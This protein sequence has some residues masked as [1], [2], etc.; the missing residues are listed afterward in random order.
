MSSR[1]SRTSPAGERSSSRADV[2]RGAARDDH[3][4]VR[5]RVPLAVLLLSAGLGALGGGVATNPRNADARPGDAAVAPPW[6]DDV[7]ALTAGVAEV[8][9]PGAV[10][11]A[12]AVFGDLAFPVLLGGA[13]GTLR[14]PLAGAATFGKGRVVAIAHG[15]FLSAGAAK[16]ADTARFLENAVRWAAGRA[17]KAPRVGVIASDLAPTLV[18]RGFAAAALDAQTWPSRLDD[19]DVVVVGE[20]SPSD[21]QR[22]ALDAF[23]R[24]GGG[25]VT[26]LCPWGWKQ[27]ARAPSLRE[28]GLQRLLAPAGLAF[29]E[30]TVERTGAQGF[31]VA[32][33]PGLAFHAARA[34]ELLAATAGR[35][36]TGLDV[37]LA[38]RVAQEAVGAL[39]PDEARLW[40]RVRAL[41]RERA[42]HLVPTAREP[43]RADRPLDRFLLAV[44][45][46]L[47]AGLPAGD[48]EAHAAAADF[49]GQTP[50]GTKAVARTVTV[51][52]RVAGWCSTGLFAVAG[53][54]VRVRAA[55]TTSA[56]PSRGPSRAPSSGARPDEAPALAV[57]IGAHADVLGSLDAWP[58]VPEVTLERPLPPEGLEV[59]S[60]FGGLVYVVVPAGGRGTIAV[61]VEGAVEAPRYE[62]GTTTKAA[63][64]Q[65]R[66]APGPWAEL[67]T[68]KVVLTVPSARVRD[69]DDPAPLL[70]F[71]DRVLDADADL[72][73]IPHARARPERIVADVEISAGYMHSGYPIMTHLDA[74]ARMVDAK[75]LATEG[76]W[77]LF[78]ELGHNHQADDWTFDGTV[79]VTCNLFTLYV[80][81]HVCG[82]RGVDGH[83]ALGA[84]AAKAAAHV[85]AGAPFD[86]WKADPFLA[87]ATYVHL[88]EG[89]GWA[90]FRA[91]FAAYRTLPDAARP[92]SDAAK[93]DAWMVRFS[94][95]V[96]RDLGPFFD[97]W[98]IP[99]GEA[100]RASLRGLPPWMPPGFPPARAR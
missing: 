75:R 59:A 49:P 94:Q 77:G 87:L 40:P 15:G 56:D 36:A 89:F 26:G 41:L 46:D 84:R 5:R 48:V 58:R 47:L 92:K 18:A 27:V 50:A 97:A 17:S 3:G 72:A 83:D 96:G 91:V 71:W 54:P 57:R 44:Q 80:L 86:A 25:L 20:G 43:M 24:R 11:G 76:D 33:P 13:G 78:H 68:S 81:E 8:A 99:T 16:V 64:A 90:P 21:P 2:A 1:A 10:P 61:T 14:L 28:N 9:A 66:R 30:A 70:A 4:P 79:E 45:V 19:V 67:A 62:Q 73:G 29:T 98:G 37:V 7:A 32:G 51:D 95:E 74:A 93:R 38:S 23:V 53:R 100:A 82:R 31:V 69:L 42:A 34:V 55:A 63:W 35:R 6:A 65:A 88:L 22:E 52:L 85:A 60:P 39:P 12:L